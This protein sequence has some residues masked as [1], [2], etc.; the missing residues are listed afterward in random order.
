MGLV[1]REA[2][3]QSATLADPGDARIGV[4]AGTMAGTAVLL[5]RNGKLRPQLVTVAQNQDVL[6]QLEAGRFDATLVS[7]D[8]L[9]AWRLS[10]P[11]SAL[12]RAAYVHPLRINLGFVA[13]AEANQVLGAANRVIERA[14]AT[15]DLQRWSDA[16]G[17]TW[18]APAEPEISGPI[19][20]AEILR[21]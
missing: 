7:L 11:G 15:G 19:G 21:E 12:R 14:L 4:T 18:I 1:V 17:S 5:Y 9:D 16:A 2:S 8:R 6:E 13:R 20:L 3:R 10:H